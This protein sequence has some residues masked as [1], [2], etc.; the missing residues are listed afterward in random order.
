MDYSGNKYSK[1]YTKSD[2]TRALIDEALSPDG[3][4]LD[5]TASY[6]REYGTK[7]LA[8][9]EKL[10][11]LT[12]LELGTNLIGVK[13]IRHITN[14]E[15][16][17]NLK[18]LNLTYNELGNEG[19]KY[20]AISDNLLTLTSLNLS[21][22]NVTDEGARAIAKFLPLFT[23][24]VRLDMRLN[25]IKEEGKKALLEA[26]KLTNIKQLLLDKEEGFQVKAV[27]N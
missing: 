6:L 26:Q 23:N 25:K 10:K 22:N 17:V 11:D 16:L 14:S 4:T 5:L 8:G 13:G 27:Q 7:D 24:L 15:Y 12:T 20:V 21:D 19:V 1:G 2:E 3:K 18:S 9:Y